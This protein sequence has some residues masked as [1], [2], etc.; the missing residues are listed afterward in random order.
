MPNTAPTESAEAIEN[1]AEAIEQV[2][3]I[4]TPETN[5]EVAA[6]VAAEA[7]GSGEDEE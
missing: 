6:T 7:A 4:E 2:E 3:G 1:G 5:G